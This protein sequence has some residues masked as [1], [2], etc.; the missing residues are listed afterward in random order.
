[1][2]E[3]R[4]ERR[5]YRSLFWP[6]LLIGVGVVWLL[7]N[8]GILSAANLVVLF[9]MWPLFLILIGLDLL[10]GRQSPTIGALIGIG[11]VVLVI[12]LM[13]VGPSLGL[14]GQMP[15]IKTAEF[16][17]P[18]DDAASASVNLALGV[19]NTTVNPLTASANLFEASIA[20][21]GDLDYNVSGTT[22]KVIRLNERGETN[23]S[24]WNFG[25]LGP[26]FNVD[27]ELDWNIGL[28]TAV[29][30]SLN[31]SGGVGSSTLNLGQLQLT[32]LTLNVGVGSANLT[33]PSAEEAYNVTVSGG[34]GET[35]ISVP[36]NAAVNITINGG[37][38][39]TTIDVPDGAAVRVDARSGVG[40]I[41]VPSGFTRTSGSDEQFL[42]SSGIWETPGYDSASRQISIRFEGGVGGL[43]I[44]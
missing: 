15:E 29:P 4:I 37:V 33:L 21:V 19:G 7:G 35:T 14:A 31:I 44:R 13:L 18:R 10:F 16:S 40:S 42:S 41:N 20:Y 22:Q 6:I 43:T 25:F 26:I 34:V 32:G 17:E 5:G 38:G 3:T 36:D 11:A 12:A 1:M 28:S 27:Q 8:L 23:V 2:G 24:N 30:L 39:S 9:R